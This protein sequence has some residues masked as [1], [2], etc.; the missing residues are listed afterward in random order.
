MS[1][2]PLITTNTQTLAE[3]KDLC[4]RYQKWV[5]VPA[6]DQARFMSIFLFNSGRFGT[7]IF[8]TPDTAFNTFANLIIEGKSIE[9]FIAF[10][11]APLTDQAQV[12]SALL[13][14]LVAEMN[15]NQAEL[16]KHIKA[17]RPTTREQ[18][19]RVR[20][21]WQLNHA[22]AL[23]NQLSP[24]QQH[25]LNLVVN[26]INPKVEVQTPIAQE[27]EKIAAAVV[28]TV[29]DISTITP[30]ELAQATAVII[31][32]AAVLDLNNI[33]DLAIATDL[34]IQA[35]VK[36]YSS[37]ITDLA[38]E[39]NLATQTLT[40]ATYISQTVTPVE[41][42]VI[43][44]ETHSVTHFDRVNLTKEVNLTPAK[45]RIQQIALFDPRITDYIENIHEYTQDAV[46]KIAEIKA[47]TAL[48]EAI[49][50]PL[51][52]E[53]VTAIIREA[54][55]LN[56]NNI[57]SVPNQQAS[58][59]IGLLRNLPTNPNLS[60]AGLR[61]AAAGVDLAKLQQIAAANPKSKLNKLLLN[62]KYIAGLYQAQQT[63]TNI[64]SA[65]IYNTA[66]RQ[67]FATDVYQQPSG[68]SA[69]FNSLTNK[70]SGFL[71]AR[72]S[73]PLNYVLHPIA[74][75]KSWVGQRAG[76]YI[77]NKFIGVL[78]QTALGNVGKL[79][80]QNGLAGGL[81][82]IAIQVALKAAGKFA[83][84]KLG[85]A[86][87]TR[88][89]LGTAGGPVGWALAIASV[90]GQWLLEKLI[91]HPEQVAMAPITAIAAL[92]GLGAAVAAPGQ[93]LTSVTGAAVTGVAVASSAMTTIIIAAVAAL[94][95][96][97]TAF[98]AA[99]L[100]ST[101]VQLQ[102][103]TLFNTSIPK[104][105]ADLTP[106]EGMG[107]M[108]FTNEEANWSEANKKSMQDQ[109]IYLTANSPGYINRVCGTCNVAKDVKGKTNFTSAD[110][111]PE[112][113]ARAIKIATRPSDP[114]GPDFRGLNGKPGGKIIFFSN[115]FLEGDSSIHY[116][117][118]HEL[119][120]ELNWDHEE[121]FQQFRTS[122]S[123]LTPGIGC[124]S[125]LPSYRWGF[126][127]TEDFAESFAWYA[128]FQRYHGGCRTNSIN[129]THFCYQ[130]YP[131]KWPNHFNFA[132][133]IFGK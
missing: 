23:A 51:P 86:I 2:V 101:L 75:F 21:I 103:G 131:T 25:D 123:C 113:K 66:T 47:A 64:K 129:G 85:V 91:K 40:A 94:F 36:T 107:C 30:Q 132:K 48:A 26:S 12:N 27:A 59:A 3:L 49:V 114:N 68:I 97:L 89:A 1:A 7:W 31:A 17:S 73:G 79:L 128:T 93:F 46:A 41:S 44:P 111:S 61:L 24:E 10:K 4:S 84:T 20:K 120:H 39:I 43:S 104:I 45:T 70:F 57:L 71:P 110:F 102:S 80:L 35:A 13:S 33:D 116:T 127:L 15:A 117:L 115:M 108:Y 6:S 130:D 90:V 87:A 55:K 60:V 100:I 63:I 67:S 96:Y 98:T 118:T 18:V 109:I 34:A 58:Q 29:V 124:E 37:P 112:C 82:K 95:L 121:I 38:D 99:P 69:R 22:R 122:V 72:L 119:G 11:E 106:V 9:D 74:S 52:D 81:K 32:A 28:A 77:A 76:Q 19:E 126:S 62:P 54:A 92:S 50:P 125:Y 65:P 16:D 14:K 78:G 83:A 42:D 56:P 88:L 8:E 53:V 133:T 105:P 5:D